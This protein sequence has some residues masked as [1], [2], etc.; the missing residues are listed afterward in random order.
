M[1][2]ERGWRELARG[3][4]YLCVISGSLCSV[5]LLPLVNAARL[6]VSSGGGAGEGGL[7]S[8]AWLWAG[9]RGLAVSVKVSTGV[10][11]GKCSQ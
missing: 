10:C 7:Y 11:L 3:S 2:A 6:P 8:S 5:L 4:L 1:F 9:L